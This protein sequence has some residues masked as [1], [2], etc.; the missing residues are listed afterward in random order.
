MLIFMMVTCFLNLFSELTAMSMFHLYRKALSQLRNSSTC[1][2]LYD[3]VFFSNFAF[4][5]QEDPAIIRFEAQ[6]SFLSEYTYFKPTFRSVRLFLGVII[7]PMVAIG[8][9]TEYYRVGFQRI[10]FHV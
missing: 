1:F 9:A 7:G 4:L 6:N 2:L 3:L 8:I 5:L 10:I